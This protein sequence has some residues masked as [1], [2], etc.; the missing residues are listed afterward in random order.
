VLRVKIDVESIGLYLNKKNLAAVEI[1]TK[2][3]HIL[4]DG[5]IGYLTVTR[6]L[7]KQSFA[8]S[9]TLPPGDCEIRGPDAIDNAIPQALDEQPLHHFI[10]LP[11]G[12]Q[13]R[14]QLFDT[15]W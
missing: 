3:D 13:F 6:Y 14:C 1:H 15:V 2:I 4:G 8:D 9:S 12:S 7:H 10:R 5:I 11:R